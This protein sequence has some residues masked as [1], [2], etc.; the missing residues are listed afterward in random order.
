MICVKE[1]EPLAKYTTFK[2]GG[3][4]KFFIEVDSADLLVEA[5][6]WV[7]KN[8]KKFFVI[9][10]GSNLLIDDKGFDG[11][12]IRLNGG[13][14][15][16]ADNQVKAFAGASLAAMIRKTIEAGLTGL[17]FAANIP[18]AV[19][20]AV[21]GNAGA[22]GKGVGAFVEKVEALFVDTMELKWLSREECE[23]GY[24]D[25]LFKKK[26]GI[27]IVNVEFKLPRAEVDP[28]QTLALIQKEWN[29]RQLK[30]PLEYPSAG[31]AFV[32]IEATNGKIAA[33]GLIEKCGL[34]GKKIGGAQISEKH[35][36]FIINVDNAKAEDVIA[37]IALVKD[38][39]KQRF[40]VELREEIQYLNF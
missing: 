27:I 40:G 21:R 7:K 10:A 23:F 25:S 32:N 2:I 36:N 9:G 5:I 29:E 14:I 16:I 6:Q 39:V 22:Y 11:L 4:A 1:N 28:A 24:R 37:L 38:T 13:E 15:K 35:A 26:D 8:N 30:Q 20:G 31:C 12:I 19:G 34:K 17:E 18:G 3:P 33:G